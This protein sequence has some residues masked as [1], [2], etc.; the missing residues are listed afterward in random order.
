MHWLNIS[1]IHIYS[2][3]F[4]YIRNSKFT[5]YS[6]GGWVIRDDLVAATVHMKFYIGCW[7]T[8]SLRCIV[9]SNEYKFIKFNEY[10]Y[11][12]IIN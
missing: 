5:I 12:F 9:S 3:S 8:L 2:C 1:H 11:S 10:I 6:L 4:I 7:I